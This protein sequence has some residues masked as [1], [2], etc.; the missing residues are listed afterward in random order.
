M[1]KIFESRY[2][3]EAHHQSPGSIDS[4]GKTY[5]RYAAIDGWV[6]ILTLQ[7][8]GKKRMA[9]A[10]FLRGYRMDQA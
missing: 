10:D 1:L 5:I 8:E 7:L 2:S 6:N 4:D 3:T 9:V